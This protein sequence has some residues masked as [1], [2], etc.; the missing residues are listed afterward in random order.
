MAA[1]ATAFRKAR[2]AIE[3]R[4]IPHMALEQKAEGV[5]LQ[6]GR[7]SGMLPFLSLADSNELNRRIP[8]V[9]LF[10]SCHCRPAGCR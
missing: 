1:R 7:V 8:C 5:N 4:S 10:D 3:A 2:E 6:R 9:A